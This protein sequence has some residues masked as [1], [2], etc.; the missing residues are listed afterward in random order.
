MSETRKVKVNYRSSH[1]KYVPA[2]ILQG[3][4][5]EQYGFS[6]D[7]FI[8]VE[9]EAGK[10]TITPR[11]PD[12]GERKKSIE[13]RISSMNKAQRKKLEELLDELEK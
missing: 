4:W 5:L 12:G 11:E 2:I 6:T 8:S 10:L 7:T 9:C 13:D 1:E 3:K